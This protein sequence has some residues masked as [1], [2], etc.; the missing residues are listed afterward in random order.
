MNRI[1]R[2]KEFVGEKPWDSI[3]IAQMNKITTKLHWTD[4]PY[5]WHINTGEEVFAVL[6]GTVDMHFRENGVENQVCLEPGDIFFAGN[7]CEHVAKPRG[8]ARILV[9]EHAGSI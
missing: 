9:V 8:A 2:A 7:G 6:D 5:K 1:F 3:P 4:A